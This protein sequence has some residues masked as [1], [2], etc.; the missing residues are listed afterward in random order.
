MNKGNEVIQV[1]E[2]E[3]ADYYQPQSYERDIKDEEQKIEQ[4]AIKY[5]RKLFFRTY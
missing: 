2:R 3:F 4:D 5:S 1:W